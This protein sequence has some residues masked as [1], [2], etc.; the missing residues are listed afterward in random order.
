LFTFH[1]GP[2]SLL[3]AVEAKMQGGQ[4]NRPQYRAQNFAMTSAVAGPRQ[5]ANPSAAQLQYVQ[6]RF[7]GLAS[8][9][10][11]AN[12]SVITFLPGQCRQ[13]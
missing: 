5:A 12:R 1:R 4:K 8:P 6:S 11:S 7:P 2:Q 10:D 3:E 9:P 13:T